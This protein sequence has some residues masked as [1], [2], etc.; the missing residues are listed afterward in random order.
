MPSIVIPLGSTERH[1]PHPPLD[2]DTRIAAAVAPDCH[3]E[4]QAEDLPIA[5]E[6]LMAPAMPTAPAAQTPPVSLERRSALKPPDDARGVCG[7]SAACRARR[8]VFVNGHAG[9]VGAFDPS[10]SLR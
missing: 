10:G 6:W 1:G 2:T 5:R 3:R 4:P 7:R 8:L 9:N